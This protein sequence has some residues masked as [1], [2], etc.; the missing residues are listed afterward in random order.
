MNA[1]PIFALS[2][3]RALAGS[4]FASDHFVES[5]GRFGLCFALGLVAYG[6]WLAHRSLPRNGRKPNLPNE[7]W[8]QVC[9]H[10]PLD[11]VRHLSS[12]DRH[13]YTT[14]RALGFSEYRLQVWH[15]DDKYYP[16]SKIESAFD[17]L[18]F[19]SSPTTAPHVRTCIVKGNFPPSIMQM[20]L[21]D[22]NEVVEPPRHM[23]MQSFYDRLPLFS[24]L[25]S[26]QLHRIQLTQIGLAN[27]CTLPSLTHI[28]MAHCS[29]AQGEIL[30]VDSLTLKVKSF[31]A[32]KNAGFNLPRLLCPATLERL[33]ICHWT[34]LAEFDIG[35]FPH[36]R[37]L[38]MTD[39]LD[40][41][42]ME[43]TD[44]FRVLTRFP[45]VRT[46]GLLYRNQLAGSASPEAILPMLQE[47]IGDLDNLGP[48]IH[49][50]ALT[51]IALF[52]YP[53]VP[54]TFDRFTDALESAGI[55]E[56]PKIVSLTVPF[57]A[58]GF[59]E[60]NFT[61]LFTV[62]PRL[63][64]FRLR[65][66]PNEVDEDGLDTPGPLSLLDAL[67]NETLLP[68]TLKTLSVRWN[69]RYYEWETLSE[70]EKIPASDTY[71]FAELRDKLLAR[72]P[73]LTYLYVEAAHFSYLWWKQQEVWE[74]T[75]RSIEETKRLSEK[76]PEHG[77]RLFEAGA[78]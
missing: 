61:R 30:D 65:F 74:V 62:F 8:L 14:V 28:S 19:F 1:P 48:F 73:H 40:V 72:C 60:S 52:P 54:I 23:F 18:A 32:Y 34:G 3:W 6:L 75:T 63:E 39:G 31:S 24:R 36:V 10:L 33:E 2:F 47:Y 29:V 42:T 46:L 16:S 21:P 78:C 56:L 11:S 26:L 49:H 45:A 51:S 58:G 59:R 69:Y 35:P 25:D 53:Y 7:L 64:E 77:D 55:I 4:A 38:R 50:S 44:E 67:A 12:T 17:R 71:D 27:I 70:P 37:A 43:L 76:L 20:D 57:K 66:T 68:P 13:L 9:S 41:G 22:F 15:V 5:P